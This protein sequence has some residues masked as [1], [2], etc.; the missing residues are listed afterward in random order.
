MDVEICLPLQKCAFILV[1]SG[2]HICCNIWRLLIRE[3]LVVK[4]RVFNPLDKFD[5]QVFRGNYTVR[6]LPQ[7]SSQDLFTW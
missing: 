4:Q 5:V 1:V 3:K 6:Q 7:L 2:Y